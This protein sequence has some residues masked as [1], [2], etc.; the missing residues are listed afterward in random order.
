[1]GRPRK[2]DVERIED[3]FF[4]MSLADQDSMLRTLELLHRMKKRQ[5]SDRFAEPAKASA[6]PLLD[7]VEK[8][9]P[10]RTPGAAAI[11]GE[12]E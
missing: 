7:E 11:L 2:T 1:M 6:T 9:Y 12:P 4:D 5:A 8:R 3:D 10:N